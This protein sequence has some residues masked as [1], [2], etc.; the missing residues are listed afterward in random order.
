MD[1]NRPVKRALA[2]RTKDHLKVLGRYIGVGTLASIV[3]LT[4]PMMAVAGGMDRRHAIW[5]GLAGAAVISYSGH[6][7]YT[8]K[9]ED[10]VRIFLKYLVLLII[11]YF[12]FSW[13]IDIISK[14]HGN[15]YL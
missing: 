10:N 3:F 8:F 6:V 1:S 15:T 9:V 14:V 5:I 4:V 13:M 7:R 12:I 2:F 11:N